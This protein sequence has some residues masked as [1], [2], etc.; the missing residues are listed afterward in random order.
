M[1]G[2]YSVCGNC[3]RDVF[4]GGDRTNQAFKSEADA[5]SDKQRQAVRDRAERA[6]Q[7][8]REEEARL[9]EA[10][11]V[12]ELKEQKK[13]VTYSG[14]VCAVALGFFLMME[15]MFLGAWFFLGKVGGGTL[16]NHPL[17]NSLFYGMHFTTF[18]FFVMW[19]AI[20]DMRSALLGFPIGPVVLS[21]IGAVLTLL[22]WPASSIW[23]PFICVCVLVAIIF[24][25]EVIRSVYNGSEHRA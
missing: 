18:A 13:Y 22:G 19:L 5:A 8:K 3:R 10:N 15:L 14:L 1:P 11:R 16:S 20:R 2:R 9:R 12:H 4:W 21:L 23:W 24:S 6:E 17:D 7:A 25:V